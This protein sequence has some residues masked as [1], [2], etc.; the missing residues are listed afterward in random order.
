MTYAVVNRP[1][2]TMAAA[3]NRIRRTV[4]SDNPIPKGMAAN[5]SRVTSG[6]PSPSLGK[7]IGLGYVPRSLC[8]AG[9]AL[10]V[11]IRGKE[12]SAQIVETPFI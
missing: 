4:H 12:V 5:A 7:S 10:T 11:I 8:Q 6:A 1:D 9:Q 2:R 3:P